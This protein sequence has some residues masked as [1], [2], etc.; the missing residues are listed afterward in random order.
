MLFNEQELPSRYGNAYICTCI[1]SCEPD[2]RIRTDG[3]AVDAQ[4][5]ISRFGR[6]LG[7]YVDLRHSRTMT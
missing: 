2:L 5:H 3:V 1:N 7:E 4:G 6:G